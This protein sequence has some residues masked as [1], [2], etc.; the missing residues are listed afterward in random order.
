MELFPEF[1][2]QPKPESS[3]AQLDKRKPK[4]PGAPDGNRGL[5]GELFSLAYTLRDIEPWDMVHESEVIGLIHPVSGQLHV[6]S[7]LGGG[8]TV[9]AL[10]Y[11]QYPESITFWQDAFQDKDIEG[12]FLA[13][14]R[15]RLLECEWVEPEDADSEDLRLYQKF[16]A[17]RYKGNPKN[18]PANF[19]CFRRYDPG[20]LP[21]FIEEENALELIWAMRLFLRYLEETHDER[22]AMCG[23]RLPGCLPVIPVYRLGE[24]G[25]PA[26]PDD[27]N[28]SKEAF[29][30]EA[31]HVEIP[32]PEAIE[33]EN[34]L[35]VCKEIWEI[36]SF[37]IPD[38]IADGGR[39]YFGKTALCMR[40]DE[41]KIPFPAAPIV[42][43]GEN[44]SDT[45]AI[46]E[47]FSKT[48][49]SVEYLPSKLR[50]ASETA[51]CALL[52]TSEK[53]GF[54]LSLEEQEC[55]PSFASEMI[56]SFP[57]SW[58]DFESEEDWDEDGE[59]EESVFLR[60]F[61]SD[62]PDALLSALPPDLFDKLSDND[63]TDV[64]EMVNSQLV[65]LEKSGLLPFAPPPDN[66]IHA[67]FLGSA[68]EEM[69]TPDFSELIGEE[70][71][72]LRVSIDGVDPEVWREMTIPIDATFL[73]LHCV[74]Q[75]IF[76]W[77]NDEEFQFVIGTGSGRTILGP[78]EKTTETESLINQIGRRRK[79]F[80]YGY[81]VEESD[82]KLSI[83]ILGIEKPEKPGS[84][85]SCCGG[86]EPSPL[87]D[88]GGPK[89]WNALRA[90]SHP[91]NISK[92]FDW[93]FYAKSMAFDANEVDR[94][95]KLF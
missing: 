44:S 35:P 36:G 18:L 50:V 84:H 39:P 12:D 58:D 47:I 78:D 65:E 76:E 64:I 67:D 25:D 52:A 81:S 71:Y 1:D 74:I 22:E 6:I 17:D 24:N 34:E 33:F 70:H 73:H 88:C 41:R 85:P 3:I 80:Q 66:I 55:L 62:I 14:N 53:L 30:K 60:Q 45:D 54:E 79:K 38:P 49:E 72:R 32:E 15:M 43:G 42:Y 13:I 63:L 46:R 95:L 68:D 90:G 40:L 89:Q 51:R 21:W 26:N 92:E 31:L 83:R 61:A 87:E 4:A 27:W 91:A 7:V 29:P 23:L 10:H 11:H 37:F 5:M 9:F 16:A 19:P 93:E 59:E 48:A 86:E 20:F 94:E 8:G 28:L 69:S 77:S 75:E 56:G 82:W 2:Y 57:S